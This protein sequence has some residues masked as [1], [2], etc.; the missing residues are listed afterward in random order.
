MTA[1]MSA[2]SQQPAPV[3][4]GWFWTIPGW[5]DPVSSVATPRLPIMAVTG[6]EGWS[7]FFSYVLRLRAT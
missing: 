4:G 2:G 7:A 3:M 5:P 6:L 1:L